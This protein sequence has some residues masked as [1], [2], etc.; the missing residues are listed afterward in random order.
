MLNSRKTNTINSIRS[1]AFRVDFSHNFIYYF[2]FRSHREDHVCRM[3]KQ[4]YN[5]FHHISVSSLM[6]IM[7]GITPISYTLYF[8]LC[9]QFVFLNKCLEI[10]TRSEVTC[11]EHNRTVSCRSISTMATTR[12]VWRKPSARCTPRR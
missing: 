10:R 4:L 9:Q 8:C 1:N 12:R 2:L 11:R 6:L 5:V 3:R 7:H